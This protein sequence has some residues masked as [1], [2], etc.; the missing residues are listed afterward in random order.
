MH[1]SHRLDVFL[2]SVVEFFTKHVKLTIEFCDIAVEMSDVT[3]DS[4]DGAALVGNLRVDYHKIF[5][6]FLHVAL[7]LAQ[8]L[9]LGD[10]LFFYLGTFVFETLDR[11][12]LIIGCFFI[13]FCGCLPFLLGSSRR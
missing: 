10:N 13:F 12:S 7:V 4:V 2:F 1:I 9:L 5:Q 11:G 3:S 8:F 6:S